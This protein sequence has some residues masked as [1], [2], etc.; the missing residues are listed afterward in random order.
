[1]T[2]SNEREAILNIYFMKNAV[3]AP[4]WSGQD[5]KFDKLPLIAIDTKSPINKL[6]NFDYHGHIWIF[7]IL[8]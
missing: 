1:M 8:I 2:T 4:K 3:Q 5:L 7:K 6:C